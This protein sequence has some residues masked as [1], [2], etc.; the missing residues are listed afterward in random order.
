MDRPQLEPKETCERFRQPNLELLMARSILSS[1]LGHNGLSTWDMHDAKRAVRLTIDSMMTS[2]SD[3]RAI[4]QPTHAIW[5]RRIHPS[6]ERQWRGFSAR[7]R[8]KF[9]FDVLDQFANQFHGLIGVAS[10]RSLC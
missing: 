1:F 3:K 4:R 6:G 9:I 2:I 10:S 7:S 5:L 8:T